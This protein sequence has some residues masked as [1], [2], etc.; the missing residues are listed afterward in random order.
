MSFFL[1]T[2]YSLLFILS[3][4]HPITQ[5]RNYYGLSQANLAIY[6]S[7]S[8]SLLKMVEQGKRELPAPAAIKLTRLQSHAFGTPKPKGKQPNPPLAADTDKRILKELQNYIRRYENLVRKNELLLTN[9]QAREQKAMHCQQLIQQLLHELHPG[10]EGKKD[11]IWLE[12][13]ELEVK[14]ELKLYGAAAQALLQWR[15]T[16]YIYSIAA[17]KKVVTGFPKK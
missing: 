10:E 17:A 7:V 11:K 4:V 15:T 1:D 6:L 13:L 3:V 14:D 2:L 12:L 8:V 9:M 5:L 16:C